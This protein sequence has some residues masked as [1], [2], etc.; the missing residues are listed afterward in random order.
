MRRVV[1]EKVI[2]VLL[3]LIPFP[4]NTLTYA[5][6]FAM[7]AYG[8]GGGVWYMASSGENGLHPDLAIKTVMGGLAIVG[9]RRALPDKE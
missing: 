5:T 2:Q 9:F 8:L 7:I 3:K 1:M 4:P 6:G